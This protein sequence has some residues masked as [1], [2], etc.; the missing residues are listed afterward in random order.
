MADDLV[1]D[2]NVA[3]IERADR[4]P[5]YLVTSP[6]YIVQ[7]GIWRAGDTVRREAA[8]FRAVA[9]VELAKAQ[10]E[11]DFVTIA[12]VAQALETVGGRTRLVADGLAGG[13]RETDIAVELGTRP[14]A[15][16]Y[17]KRKLRRALAEKI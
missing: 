2:A 14:Q 5:T 16:T 11:T 15:I 17:H 8:Y 1:Q 4:D 7:L 6:A 13:M 9:P 3:I 10:V 12:T